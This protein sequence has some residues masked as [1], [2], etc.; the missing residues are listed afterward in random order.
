MSHFRLLVVVTLPLAATSSFF[1]LDD[2][3]T[4][5]ELAQR[6]AKLFACLLDKLN[7]LLRELPFSR[8]RDFDQRFVSSILS[9]QGYHLSQT[10]IDICVKIIARNHP[11]FRGLDAN[12]VDEWLRNE[13]EKSIPAA[14]D[15]SLKSEVSQVI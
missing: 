4:P 6:N 13:A 5:V 12:G 1:S 7:E 11:R 3:M 8:L 2:A 14:S 15:T 9:Q 10:Q